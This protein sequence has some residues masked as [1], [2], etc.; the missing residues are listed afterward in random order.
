M[1]DDQRHG[2]TGPVPLFFRIRCV[3]KPIAP[4]F[5]T[6]A[7]IRMEIAGK[8]LE[9]GA[10]L[11]ILETETE[12]HEDGSVTY[13]ARCNVASLDAEVPTCRLVW[14]LGDSIVPVF[15]S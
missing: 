13:G 2:Q 6:G 10:A 4:S 7:Q 1:T 15:V 11:V 3:R 5:L 14:Q 12:N 9:Y 8:C